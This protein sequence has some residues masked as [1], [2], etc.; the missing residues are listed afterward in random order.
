MVVDQLGKAGL[1]TIALEDVSHALTSVSNK[2]ALDSKSFPFELLE[3]SIGDEACHVFVV[4][5]VQLPAHNGFMGAFFRFSRFLFVLVGPQ[6]SEAEL[7]SLGHSLAVLSTDEDLMSSLAQVS[8]NSAF[9]NAIDVRLANLT[10]IPHAYL[11]TKSVTS[12]SS[13]G[14]WDKKF[15]HHPEHSGEEEMEPDSP[16]TTRSKKSDRSPEPGSPKLQR[17]NS[18]NSS[19]SDQT[20]ISAALAY[21]S[22]QQKGKSWKARLKKAAKWTI[23]KLQKYSVPLVVGVT[24]AMVWSNIDKESYEKWTHG[25]ISDWELVGHEVSLHFFVNDIFMCFFFGLAIKEVT[26]AVLPGGSLSPIRRAA[27]PLMATLGGVVGPVVVY[28]L[29][30]AI[31]EKAGSF[32]GTLCVTVSSNGDDHRRLGGGGAAAP[33][34]PKEQ[35]SLSMLLKGWGV[36][37]ATDISLAWMFALLIF[38]A[39]HPAINVLLLLAIVDDALG[40]VIIA[41]FYPNPEKPVEPIWLLLVLLA[42]VLSVI[43]RKLHISYWQV[44]VLIPG[45][46]SWLGLIKA[47]VHP[48][49]ALVFVVPFM[50]AHRPKVRKGAKN[51]S[52]MARLGTISKAISKVADMLPDTSAKKGHEGEGE[53][54]DER[55]A[56]VKK[57]A[58]QLMLHAHAPLHAFEHALKLPVDL[59]MFFFGLANAGVQLGAFGGIT[60][61]VITALLVGKTLGIAGFGMLAMSMGFA[62]PTGV[63][64]VDLVSMSALGGVGLTVALFVANQ[65]FVDP[66][67]QG[68]AKMGAVLSVGCAFFAWAFRVIGYKICPRPVDDECEVFI[69]DVDDDEELDM[70]TGEWIDDF[71]VE[72]IMQIMW[73]H[74]QYKLRGMKMPMNRASIRAASKEHSRASGRMSVDGGRM[75][76]TGLTSSISSIDFGPLRRTSSGPAEPPSAPT[77][78]GPYNSEDASDPR[79][80]PPSKSS[81]NLLEIPKSTDE[82]RASASMLRQASSPAIV[83][84]S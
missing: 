61:S 40:M 23:A 60:V 49:L 15:P 20:S 19:T 21:H 78:E 66:D 81:G 35:C 58:E 16:K 71:L 75:S 10:F 65:A 68:Q 9:I 28:Y 62:L 54:L 30:V 41:V 31:M 37:T 5:S 43:L 7:L 26:E 70:E 32:E 1:P 59:G 74:R 44:F 55:S 12:P 42:M 73:T 77:Y 47:H 22:K 56:A 3:P 46:V 24:A 83:A 72:D 25:Q 63:T 50:P 18:L 51:D 52:Y 13:A 39:G 67:L 36:P 17:S 6:S 34:G 69:T 38:G 29:M 45:P 57:A 8:D 53:E 80:N 82:A 14:S 11:T 64:M 33:T 4:P 2:R 27:N 79:N 48:A 76:V 84:H